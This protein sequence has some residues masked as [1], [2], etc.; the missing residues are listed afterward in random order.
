MRL[1][2]SVYLD[3]LKTEASLDS[4]SIQEQ[5]TWEATEPSLGELYSLP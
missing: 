4:A 3:V 5:V 2:L 1:F